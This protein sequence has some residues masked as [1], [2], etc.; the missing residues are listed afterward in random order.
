A[1]QA[2]GADGPPDA[3]RHQDGQ[4]DLFRQPFAGAVALGNLDA[5]LELGGTAHSETLPVANRP[6]H[7]R[8]ASGIG[9]QTAML[10]RR[11][12][13]LRSSPR[14]RSLN[15]WRPPFSRKETRTT[16]RPKPISRPSTEPAQARNWV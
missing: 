1:R 11:L 14:P 15:K 12:A 5:V 16:V 9:P 3:Q 2:V 10:D 13:V 4:G 8:T 7:N 6:T